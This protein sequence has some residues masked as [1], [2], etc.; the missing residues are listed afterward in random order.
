MD[1]SLP[2]GRRLGYQV[3]GDPD[4]RPIVLLHGTPGSAR[5]VAG[6]S[7]RATD[8]GLAMITPDRAGYGHSTH[9]PGRTVASS[10]RDI[11]QLIGRLGLGR[12][13]VVGL[14]GGGPTAL[15]CGALADQVCA[16]ATVGGVGPL[17]PRDPS[18]P[19]DRLVIKMAR[20]S[21]AGTAMLFS[22][23]QRSGRRRPDKALARF[24]RMMAEPDADLLRDDQQL[25]DAFIDDLGHPSPSTAKAAARDFRLFALAWDVDLASITVPVHVW[26]GTADRNV[27]VAHARVIAA[28]CPAAELH[29]VEGGGH[30][31]LD[32]LDP[33]IASI[34]TTKD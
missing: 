10:A 30:M 7:G 33:I 3:L 19:A 23:I 14:S 1:I 4:G 13:P 22:V 20:R 5:Q 18:L 27:P 12:C 31:L 29:V 34:M 8:R 17:V 28:R 9:D 2:D 15:A 32:Q 24:A 21:E 26:H 16:V 11:G 6:L 25:R